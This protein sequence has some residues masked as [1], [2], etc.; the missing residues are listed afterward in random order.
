MQWPR[1]PAIE[2]PLQ[3]YVGARRVVMTQMD[4]D[5]IKRSLTANHHP[6][7]HCG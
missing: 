1:R 3:R 5:A 7:G 4:Q 6:E 2:P